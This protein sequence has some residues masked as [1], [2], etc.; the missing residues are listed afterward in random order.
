M[1]FLAKTQ[2]WQDIQVYILCY[3]CFWMMLM[4]DH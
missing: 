1:T 2:P 4:V 3:V